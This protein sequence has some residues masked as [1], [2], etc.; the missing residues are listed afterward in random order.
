MREIHV[1]SKNNGIDTD[2]LFKEKVIGN[3]R[4]FWSLSQS[5]SDRFHY[6][7]YDEESIIKKDLSVLKEKIK[8]LSYE[9]ILILL[10]SVRERVIWLLKFISYNVEL[11]AASVRT[12]DKHHNLETFDEEMD[13]FHSTYS[14]VDGQRLQCIISYIDEWIL[15]IDQKSGSRV[16]DQEK[17][18]VKEKEESNEVQ[19]EK[20]T[21]ATNDDDRSQSTGSNT[22]SNRRRNKITKFFVEKIIKNK[23]QGKRLIELL[24]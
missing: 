13:Y 6:F 1:C 20:S 17:G 10:G 18:N 12:F 23:R 15:D 16:E 24:R 2:L 3:E 14:F 7:Y 9:D 8:P 5:H 22:S 11:F 21:D 4:C 19:L